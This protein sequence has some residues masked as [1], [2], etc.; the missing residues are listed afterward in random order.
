MPN[1]RQPIARIGSTNIYTPDPAPVAPEV[2]PFVKALAVNANKA[3]L[4]SL[5]T[6][7]LKDLLDKPPQLQNAGTVMM[8][9]RMRAVV[10][11]VVSDKSGATRAGI[12][13]RLFDQDTKALLDHSRT[14]R[15]G[16]VLLRFPMPSGDRTAPTLGTV[17]FADGSNSVDVS[18]PAAPKQHVLITFVLDTLPPLPDPPLAG[19]NP[20]ARLPRDFTTDLCDTISSVLPTVNDPI[21]GG[22]VS[23][24][25]FRAQRTPIYHH[26][27]IPRTVANPAAGGPPRRFLVRVLQEWKFLGYTLGEL[28][29][30]DA[31]DPGSLV[32][33]TLSSAQQLVES[34]SRAVD[35]STSNLSQVLQS[36]LS[37]LST[38]HSLVQVATNVQSEVAAGL[39]A[40]DAGVGAL[41]GGILG[42]IPGAIVGGIFGGLSGGVG[43]N[44]GTNVSTSATTSTN[45]G[46]SLDVNSRVQF[47]RS[48]VNQA[49]RIVSSALRQTQS[50]L[51]R[52]IG[53]VSPLLTRVSNMLHW[54]LY[55][56]YAVCS[57]VEDVF[58]I[59]TE[60]FLD[61]PLPVPADIPVYFTDEDIVEYRR[62]F[63]PVLLEPLL[64]NQFSVLR[65]AIALRLA[66]G[67]PITRIRFAID[68]AASFLAADLN[69]KVGSAEINVHLPA[70]QS[71]LETV[72][73][74][75]PVLP[76]QLDQLELLLKA[77]FAP[78]P[79][80]SPFFPPPPPPT[81]S[82]TISRIEV[83]FD[84]ATAAG[85]D[86]KISSGL[87]AVSNTTPANSVPPITLNAPLRLIDTTKNS[88]FRH[89][90]RNHTYYIGVL[91][92]AALT[93]SSLRSDAQQLSVFYPYNSP[94]WRLAIL[95]F[96][97]DRALIL[98]N[99][100]PAN[101]PDVSAMLQNDMGAATIIQLAA[102]GAYGEALKGVLTLL[103]V[104]PNKLVD[105][106]T[107]I[108]PALLPPP[109]PVLGLLGGAGGSGT[110]GPPGPIGPVGPIGPIGPIGPLGPIGPQGLPGVG[111]P[112]GV[113]GATGIAGPAGPEGLPGVAGP[114]GPQ[115]LPGPPGPQG[116][117]GVPCWIAEALWGR[118]D[119]K[120]HVLR[121]WLTNV[122]DKTVPGRFVVAAYRL[123]G[124]P[125]SRVIYKYR[126]VGSAFRPIFERAF[127]RATRELGGPF[128]GAA[129][130]YHSDRGADLAQNGRRE[131]YEP[132]VPVKA[133][134]F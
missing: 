47:A 63:E 111:G 10:V 115:G 65:D 6:G 28:A 122:Y 53:R 95:G 121:F 2:H 36:A 59:Q 76:G 11:A 105:E 34:A 131:A 128:T 72:L 49:I 124:K 62:Y 82:L 91:A 102:A 8:D 51:S 94:I 60:Q 43:A 73:F 45:V 66:G 18:V 132:R 71:R 104:D 20:L 3:F 38:V 46:A 19:D 57:F 23:T 41:I 100:D 14:D 79:P 83:W 61:L 33:E 16:V 110:A 37:Q 32:R 64:A 134:R 68:Y 92:Q 22:V 67:Q 39:K 13:L 114:P 1:P 12:E 9:G 86:Q 106:A 99:I 130:Q 15:N 5:S 77:V 24:T 120:T 89:I 50:V 96:E 29:N 117:P 85:P 133:Q 26:L 93:V 103:N 108:H 80:A 88:L 75:S 109:P 81:G 78:L 55:E 107:M 116:L 27:T 40:P 87:P 25:D 52:E 101:D 97:G 127:R 44:T 113:P 21:F 17:A 98:K 31:L 84:G 74:T 112:Q 70:T 54:T 123:F 35:Q 56:N 42:G 119:L 126:L 90:N 48:I 69:I 118:D 129:A 30:V 58:E 7:A 125:I 4:E